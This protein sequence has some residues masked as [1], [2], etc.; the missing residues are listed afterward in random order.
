MGASQWRRQ[1][2]CLYSLTGIE[3]NVSPNDYACGLSNG[4]QLKFDLPFIVRWAILIC[5]G[6]DKVKFPA[7]E[8]KPLRKMNSSTK[9]NRQ[10]F[11][12]QC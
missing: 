6:L 2:L 9:R 3:L 10:N 5:K 4:Q 8:W 12:L 1:E 11:D 7:V